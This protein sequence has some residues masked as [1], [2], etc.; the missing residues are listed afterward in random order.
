MSMEAEPKKE[1]MEFILENLI[2]GARR[3]RLLVPSPTST[4]VLETP[5]CLLHTRGGLVPNLTRDLE[6]Q[7]LSL[8]PARGGGG[9]G[10]CGYMLTMPTLYKS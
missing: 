9:Q 6:N 3:G 4:H 5:S 10:N 7:L 1:K 8:S 2:Q